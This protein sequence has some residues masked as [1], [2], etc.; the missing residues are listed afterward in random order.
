MCSGAWKRNLLQMTDVKMYVFS[1]SR[2]FFVRRLWS[3]DLCHKEPLFPLIIISYLPLPSSHSYI[4]FFIFGC[5]TLMF[6]F[7]FPDMY[8]IFTQQ[9]FAFKTSC[10]AYCTELEIH[11]FNFSESVRVRVRIFAN[12]LSNNYNWQPIEA[13]I[14]LFS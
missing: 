7:P 1:S 11:W 8:S 3:A 4:F 9:N 2:F 6:F 5:H 13:Q 12:F 10:V 14:N